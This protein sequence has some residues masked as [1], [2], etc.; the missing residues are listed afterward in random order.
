MNESVTFIAKGS[1]RY[2]LHIKPEQ[3]AFGQDHSI[4]TFPA[5]TISF[6]G[7]IFRT[8]NPEKIKAIRAAEAFKNGRVFELPKGA[9]EPQQERQKTV[10]GS[11]TTKSYKE[12]AGVEEKEQRLKL[13]ESGLSICDICDPPAEFPGDFTGQKLRMHKIHA[14]GIGQMEVSK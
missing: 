3:K 6:E 1:N 7:G 5:E 13:Q 4:V 11:I 10:R 9:P 2:S 14:H 12:E 8:D